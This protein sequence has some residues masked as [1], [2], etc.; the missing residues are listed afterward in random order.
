VIFKSSPA[1]NSDDLTV[2]SLF[3]MVA[4]VFRATSPPA[5]IA[6]AIWVFCC[7]VLSVVF[8]EK[9]FFFVLFSK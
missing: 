1:A 9:N 6:A 2:M 8:F 4:A 5:V 7:V 3:A